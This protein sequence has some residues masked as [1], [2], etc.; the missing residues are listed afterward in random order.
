MVEEMQSRKYQLWMVKVDCV[1]FVIILLKNQRI[2][3]EQEAP[4]KVISFTN[5]VEGVDMVRVIIVRG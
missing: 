1:T 2:R 5:T 3:E 4:I